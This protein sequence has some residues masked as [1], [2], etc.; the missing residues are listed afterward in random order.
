MAPANTLTGA[1]VHDGIPK[2]RNSRALSKTVTEAL[3]RKAGRPNRET[4]GTRGQRGRPPERG[5]GKCPGNMP[6]TGHGRPV[7]GNHGPT[8]AGTPG[9]HPTRTRPAP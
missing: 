8:T 5:P 1:F 2:M 9:R 4:G 7:A 6:G 3:G